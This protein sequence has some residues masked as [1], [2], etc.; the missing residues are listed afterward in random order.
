MVDVVAKSMV[1][2]FCYWARMHM[3]VKPLKARRAEGVYSE[4]YRELL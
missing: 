1:A 4:K 2:I 3:R